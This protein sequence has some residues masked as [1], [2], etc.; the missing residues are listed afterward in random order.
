MSRAGG[1]NVVVLP[2][3]HNVYTVLA[4]TAFVAQAIGLFVLWWASDKVG[5]L[6]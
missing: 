5:G 2:P 3:Q 6:F 1:A 4:A